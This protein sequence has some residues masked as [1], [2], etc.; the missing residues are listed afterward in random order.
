M[1]FAFCFLNAALL[2]RG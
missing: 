2:G 1:T